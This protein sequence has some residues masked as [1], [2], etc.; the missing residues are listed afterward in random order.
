M[1]MCGRKSVTLYA[2]GDSDKLYPRPDSPSV[3]SV[4]LASPNY[5]AHP[6][7]TQATPFHFTLNPGDVLYLPP[8]WWHQ[9]RACE[10]NISVNIWWNPIF[11]WYN[12]KYPWMVAKAVLFGP[13]ASKVKLA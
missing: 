9:T 12:L 8:G 13:K 7:L 5:S 11:S 6:L 10:M 1:Q 2:P 3:S 4:D